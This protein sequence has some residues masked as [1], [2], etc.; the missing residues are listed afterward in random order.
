MLLGWLCMSI[1]FRYV[2]SLYFTMDVASTLPIQLI[3]HIISGHQGGAVFGF[4][5][6]LRL[7]RLRRVSD[8]FAR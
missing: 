5:N 3:Y 2:M 8:L 1:L 4:L 7:W 6:L